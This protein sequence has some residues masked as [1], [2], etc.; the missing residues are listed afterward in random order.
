MRIPVMA[1][2]VY[3]LRRR[4]SKRVLPTERASST[5][6]AIKNRI[7]TNEIGG[8]SRNPILIASHVELQT[9]QSVSHA[10]GTPQSAFGRH[11]FSSAVLVLFTRARAS[12]V[13]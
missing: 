5:P 11:L 3:S 6:I 12:R 10:S 13:G 4:G 7:A 8:R 1:R 9:T 2:T